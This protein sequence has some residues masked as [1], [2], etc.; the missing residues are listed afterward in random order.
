MEE[1][2]TVEE[3]KDL[4]FDQAANELKL[5]EEF[6]RKTAIAYEHF[7]YVTQEHITKFNEEIKKKTMKKEGKNQWGD[8]LTYDQL[9]FHDIKTY[10]SSPPKSVLQSIKKAK[11]MKCFDTFEIAKIESQKEVPD[12]IVFGRINGCPDLFF[13]DQ[14]LDDIK[15]S[16][17]IED[18][19]G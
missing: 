15:I 10:K 12:P 1:K 4:G 7:R 17:L 6:K 18:N 11:E 3:L 19:E 8:I 16:D 5:L 14:W 2:I 13:I 9:K